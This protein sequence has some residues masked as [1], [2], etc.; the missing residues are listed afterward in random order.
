MRQIAL[1]FSFLTFG[2]VQKNFAQVDKAK[3][4]ADS[5]FNSLNDDQRIAQLM[6]VRSSGMDAAGN[7]VLYNDVVYDLVKKYNI[8]A[9]CA[10]QGTPNQHAAFF[11]TMQSLAQTPVMITVDAEWGLGMR[12]AGVQNFPFQ[13]TMGAMSDAELVY[14]VGAAI[15]RQ[16]RRMN[17]HVN[18]A[19]VVDINNNPE[20]PV[21]GVRSFGED[22]YKVSLLGAR[23]MEGMQDN[24]VMACAKHFPGH[25]DVAV[26]SHKDLPVI[27][28]TIEQL[29]SL[30]LYPFKLLFSKGVGSVMVAHL[31]I[32]SIDT[33]ANRAT[34]LSYKNITELMRD[35]LG[36]QGLTFTDA[37]EMK[38]VS[39]FYPG[40]EVAVQSLVAGNDMLCLPENVPAAI[41]AIKN[42][43]AQGRLT[44]EQV[45]DKCKRVLTA[46]Y[47]Y[48]YGHTGAIDTAHLTRDL[49]AEIPALR[50]Q[51]AEKALTVLALAPTMLPIKNY[52]VLNKTATKKAKPKTTSDIVYIAFGTRTENELARRLKTSL[53]AD[54]LYI[55]YTD[56][57]ALNS[58]SISKLKAYKKIIIGLHGIARYPAR[59]F[60]IPEQAV[61]LINKLQSTYSNAL[62]FNFGNPYVIKNFPASK[63]LVVCYEDD[64][65]FQGVA[66]DWLLGRFEAK[67]TLPVTIGDYSYG[68]GI[69]KKNSLPVASP[70]SV[71]L[72]GEILSGID[73]IA[74][75][76][77]AAK[78][79]PGCVVAIA[80]NGKLVFCK[81]YGTYTYDEGRPVSTSTIYDMASVTKIAATTLCVMKLYEDG[82]IDLKAPI[83]K[84]LPWLQGSG[85]ESL[86]VENLLMH[87]AGLNS[88]IPFYKEITNEA[89]E[90]S[91]Y[92]F[93]NYK[94]EPFQT[95]V[96]NA[97][98]MR[99]DWEDSMVERIKTSEV[100]SEQV[101]Y[102]YSDNDFILMGKI[103]ESVSG[104]SLDEYAATFF[105]KPLGLINTSFKAYNHFP[106]DRVAPTE[107]E[108]QFRRQLLWGYVH[109]PGAA[110]F[111]NVSGHAGLFSN[112]TDLT[113]LFQMLLNGGFY[114]NQRYLKKETIDFFTSYR[115]PVS[116]RGL[117]FDKP[118]KDNEFRT[119]EKAYPCKSA[120]PRTYGH[121]GYTGTCV[122]ADPANSLCFVFLSNRVNPDGG[123]NNK[124]AQMNIRSRIQE[125]IYQSIIQ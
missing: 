1:L 48:V 113:I 42:A 96:T 63:N 5:V 87:Q 83:G 46:K 27:E 10:F 24:G 86:T 23:I 78:A 124:L 81:S 19:P 12:F 54:V 56:T 34:S 67:G 97:L 93:A 114:N 92:L 2:L 58:F 33:T 36:Y 74:N 90:P 22:K 40:G 99:S 59:N 91:P 18:Y 9:I 26:D 4:W 121:T 77:I 13:L 107:N 110:M 117:G 68:T 50:K 51:V 76:A 80:K 29:D 118:E 84:Y 55:P 65:V 25:G 15:A 88:F 98:Y 60:G 30:E 94:H 75:E 16:C 39:K 120:S 49:N 52:V 112:A 103:V 106:N 66:A 100:N 109:D 20:N 123:E 64:A 41:D 111:G 44:W 125:L 119:E 14:K 104:L 53:K 95:T 28:K 32:P 11:N 102:V 21:I 70:E 43:V 105:Y 38:G 79:T 7:T 85:K 72:R 3:Q 82:R 8:G 122:W 71:G 31:Y 35:K 62:L 101:K 47:Q 73:S 116:R 17:I 57:T 115:T 45:Y 108:K 37:L 89:G 61:K 6:V 69:V